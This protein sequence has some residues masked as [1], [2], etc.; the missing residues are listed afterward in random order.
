MYPGHVPRILKEIHSGD[1]VLDVGGWA[2]PFRRATHV[3]DLMPYETR[4]QY[5]SLLSDMPEHFTRDTWVRRDLCDRTPFPFPDKYFNFVIC[6]QTL[7]DLRDPIWVYAELVRIGQRGYIEVPSRR[8]EMTRGVE[9]LR[10][11][12]HYHHRWLIDVEGDTL[13]FHFKTSLVNESWR[14]H[15]PPREFDRLPQEKR[16]SSLFWYG[17]FNFCEQI[18]IEYEQVKRDLAA[19]VRQ[20]AVYSIWRYRLSDISSGV[21]RRLPRLRRWYRRWWPLA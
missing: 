4:G 5:G 11:A 2:S 16:M 12:G 10:Y 17:T 14:Y 19:Y 1:L 7:E 18:T 13:T 9:S 3:I 15:L 6:T 21:A 20:Q 8:L